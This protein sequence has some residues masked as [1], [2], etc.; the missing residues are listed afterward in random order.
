MGIWAPSLPGTET[1]QWGHKR[2]SFAFLHP[3]LC[4]NSLR[5]SQL[6][7][8]T[9]QYT[10]THTNTLTTVHRSGWYF[11]TPTSMLCTSMKRRTHAHIHSQLNTGLYWI[12]EYPLPTT[13]P[14]P[15]SSWALFPTC[16]TLYLYYPAIN[17]PLATAQ[18]PL[19]PS[20]FVHIMYFSH[21]K[22]FFQPLICLSF[23]FEGSSFC[24]CCMHLCW[25]DRKQRSCRSR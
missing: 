3:S 11:L 2:P 17:R 22:V 10:H 12:T 18:L 21:Q 9:W 14:H 4:P 5:R 23:G 24:T 1:V 7:A 15:P 25:H 6:C 8:H 20:A 19:L 13:S 16:S